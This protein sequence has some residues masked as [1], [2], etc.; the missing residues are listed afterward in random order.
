MHFPQQLT[1][2][3]RRRQLVDIYG[4]PVVFR[5]PNPLSLAQ[6]PGTVDAT[7]VDYTE[8]TTG[9]D[10]IAFT[11][12]VQ[13]TGNGQAEPGQFVPK[14]GVSGN[15]TF[16]GTAYDF[17]KSWLVNDVAA[18]LN[19]I[20]VQITDTANGVYQG[21]TIKQSALSWCEYD[22]LCTYDVTLKQEDEVTQCI[23]RELIADNWQGWFQSTPAGGKKHPRF[24]Y[25]V[26]HRPNAI[27]VIEWYLTSII[28]F[29]F[30]IIF[31]LLWP[32]FA[33]MIAIVTIINIIIAAINL[34]GASIPLMDVPT[35][36]DPLSEIR[37]WA[38]M[39][40]EAAGCGR[41]HPAPLVRDYITNICDKCGIRYSADTADIFFAPIISIQ[42]SDG[43]VH[44]KPN[45][46]YNATLLF[47]QTVRGVRRFRN[48]SLFTGYSTPDNTYYQQD[49][50]PVWALSD[51]LD[52]LK[53]EYNA[54][55]RIRSIYDTTSG[56]LVPYL[57]FKR[58]DWFE[59]TAPLYDFSIGGADRS[60]IIEGICYQ[61]QDYTV[62]ASMS[63]LYQDDPAD[64]CGHEAKA[65]MDGAPLS[66]NNTIVNPLFKGILDKKS[67]FAATKF[68]LDGSST[69]YIYDALQTFLNLF[70][71]LPIVGW[72]SPVGL[73]ASPLI[74]LVQQYCD[75][76]LLLASETTTLP[77][78][79]IWDG[80][81]T[82]PSSPVY[83]NA[84]A[85]RDRINL[86]GTVYTIGHTA[87]PATVAGIDL[88][89]PNPL[90]PSQVAA[91][92]A[93]LTTMIQPTTVPTLLDWNVAYPPQ[94]N[95]FSNPYGTLPAGVYNVRDLLGI[96]LLQSAA[97]LVNY[98]MYF[99][100]YYKDSMWD[101]F[102]WIDDPYRH[103]RLRKDWSVKI[104]LCGVDL[105]KLK[106]MK[107]ASDAELLSTVKLDSLYYNIG[108]ITEI[109]ADY[110]P[111]GQ[112][113]P[114]QH[115]ELKGYV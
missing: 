108:V 92:T 58:K 70:A 29:I 86:A 76:A 46:H 24:S 107:D 16:E 36:P 3:L 38:N 113:K 2:Q 105:T 71:G 114:G 96:P 30:T 66:F 95:V 62:P 8:F 79:L 99:S 43:D 37:G 98:P 94:T 101:W 55:W 64:K 73:I 109:T 31:T 10:K 84:R 15:L 83:T 6:A 23:Q 65:F 57:F 82:N 90:Y 104:P 1:I 11:W 87:Y 115:I 45:P 111:D 106:V 52:H 32:L 41:E 103:P 100:P 77:K 61:P 85:V 81:T 88:P 25:C 63:G 69:D 47:P 75:Y 91:S 17:I 48:W 4:V 39:M 12:S 33:I 27:L 13:Q 60:K 89:T 34:L 5:G 49:N 80:D 51:L 93:V 22:A 59:N 18:A 21:Y 19:E 42:T 14:K 40:I 110:D 35:L 20:E 102:H 74:S 7:W 56:T 112:D 53:G 50:A 67:G 72:F 44:S 78:I 97:I 28:A 9:L 68:R 54:Q 26:E